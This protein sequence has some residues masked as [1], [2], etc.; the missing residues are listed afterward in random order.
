MTATKNKTIS[1]KVP[2]GI[3]YVLGTP[4]MF[5]LPARPEPLK[6]L[7]SNTALIVVDM[8]NAYATIGGYVDMA[9][10]D[11]SGDRKSVV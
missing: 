7:V 5:E 1:S 8:Q 11:I 3:P 2:V 9:G 4:G 10:F 6:M